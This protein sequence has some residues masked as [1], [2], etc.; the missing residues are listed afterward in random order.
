MA[1][2]WDSFFSIL[3]SLKVKVSQ[4]GHWLL[5]RKKGWSAIALALLTLC[6]VVGTSPVLSQTSSESST[7]PSGINLDEAIHS[8]DSQLSLAQVVT[9]LEKR[10]TLFETTHQPRNR[11]ITLINLGRVWAELGHQLRAC[12]TLTEAFGLR[13]QVCQ[14][15]ELPAEWYS[16]ASEI[17]NRNDDVEAKSLRIFGDV[18]RTIGQ[19]DASEIVLK[20]SLAIARQP[21]LAKELEAASLL[22]LGNTF[23]AKGNLERDRQAPPNY[24]YL[25][26]QYS[27]KCIPNEGNCVPKKARTEYEKAKEAYYEAY[28]QEEIAT[29]AL[30]E[31]P[32]KAQ[33]NLLS[34]FINLEDWPTA[35][36]TFN[37]SVFTSESWTSQVPDARTRIYTRINLAKNLAFL[38]Q[39]ARIQNEQNQDFSW[40]RVQKQLTDAR[41]EAHQLG[42]RHAESYALGNLGGLYEYCSLPESAC[43]LG[44]DVQQAQK[45]TEEALYLAQPSDAPDIAYQWQWQMGRLLNAQGEREGAITVYRSA[46]TTLKAAR[47]NLFTVNTDVQFSFRDNVE[48]VYRE[49]IELLLMKKDS[50]SIKEAIREVDSLQLA[51]LQ[52]FLRCDPDQLVEVSEIRIDKTAAKIY[53]ILLKHGIAVI[54]ELPGQDPLLK[55]QKY[56]APKS[57]EKTED[58]LR[59]LHLVLK[60]SDGTPQAVK[61]LK[62]V[63]EW[64]IK[65]IELQLDQ[66]KTLVF[67]LDSSLRNIPM[68]ALVKDEGNGRDVFPTYLIHQYAVA[69]APRLKVFQPRSSPQNLNVFL[70]G[71]GSKQILESRTFEPINRLD[72][73]LNSI[74]QLA[75]SP[76]SRLS[77]S[78]PLVN[79]NF[80]KKNLELEL[81]A[82]SF[83]AIHLKTHGDFSFDPQGT[84]I[85]ASGE[86]I[87]GNDLTRLI[88]KA[89]EGA[90]DV[91]ELLVL[92]A[93]ST[94]EGDN[95]TVFGLAGI[96]AKTGIRS[97][98]STLW[99]AKDP[100]NTELMV[101]FYEELIKPST[102]K[103]QALRQAQLHLIE[104]GH[105]VPYSWS[106]YVLVGNWL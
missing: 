40:E 52:N 20:Q 61:L 60:Q 46:V 68:A 76:S 9:C 24:D 74:R 70:G 69:V 99:T 101:R 53:P 28:S 73:E 33:L 42:D 7:C 98:L 50:E 77:V 105:T 62:T 58:V 17:L 21:Q 48:P 30:L 47:G 2:K 85:V 64:V 37:Q 93:C 27:S 32:I 5:R 56:L 95:R 57:W 11:A 67:I 75:Q 100:P 45:L 38:L 55:Y 96:A 19:L 43:N 44:Q 51:E 102:T 49:L 90:N 22:S 72:E 41:D 4:M 94:A 29:K 59:K 26:W 3:R 106:T 31:L 23:R 8:Q 88:Q 39:N 10:A 15:E 79:E 80:T 83:S 18:L 82:N 25:P 86:L 1:R 91:I 97:T 54:L 63:Y 71:F 6:L 65:P 14:D 34:L 84:F 36:D 103:A 92:S 89:R 78:S 81:A 35:Q 104:L 87:K 16:F 12:Q 13:E 66:I